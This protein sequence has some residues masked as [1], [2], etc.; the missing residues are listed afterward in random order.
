MCHPYYLLHW[1]YCV[2]IFPGDLT[3]LRYSFE[4]NNRCHYMLFHLLYGIFKPRANKISDHADDLYY[5]FMWQYHQ[6][7]TYLRK[8]TMFTIRSYPVH[9]YVN[10]TCS[11]TFHVDIK[12]YRG[13]HVE[14]NDSYWKWDGKASSGK[15]IHIITAHFLKCQGLYLI[16]ISTYFLLYYI[17]VVFSKTQTPFS[18]I[19]LIYYEELVME[20]PVLWRRTW[21]FGDIFTINDAK[22]GINTSDQVQKTQAFLVMCLGLHFT[23]DQSV[24]Y[25]GNDIISG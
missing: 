8:N 4:A 10:P 23:R 22:W 2:D 24:Q 7:I 25:F 5:P 17:P 6:F 16:R 15:V 9:T 20:L 13:I 12:I 1:K 3:P 19:I 21:V 18:L 14:Y 11:E